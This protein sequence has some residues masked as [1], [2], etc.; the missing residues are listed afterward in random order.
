MKIKEKRVEKS[1]KRAGGIDERNNLTEKNSYRFFFRVL[2]GLYVKIRVGPFDK[3]VQ[4]LS[5]RVKSF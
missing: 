5:A 2:T 3:N 4:I 1:W